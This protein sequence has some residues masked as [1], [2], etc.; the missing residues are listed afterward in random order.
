MHVCCVLLLLLLFVSEVV[1]FKLPSDNDPMCQP[2]SLNLSGYC[3]GYCLSGTLMSLSNIVFI[4]LF[5]C[6][7]KCF[8]VYPFVLLRLT[9][10]V[11]NAAPV[12]QLVVVPFFVFFHPVCVMVERDDSFYGCGH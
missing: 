6:S 5:A 12:L 11:G 9:S 7:A 4:H 10:L 2:L 1:A 3:I 8:A